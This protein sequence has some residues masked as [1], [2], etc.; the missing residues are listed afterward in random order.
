MIQPRP[1]KHLGVRR[2]RGAVASSTFMLSGKRVSSAVVRNSVSISTAGSTCAS[3]AP[4]RGARSVLSSCMSPSSGE[5]LLLH[6]AAICSMRRAFCDLV[7]NLGDDDL[8][9]AVLALSTLP[10]RAHAESA[11]AG[12]VGLRIA[13][14]S[15]RGCRRSGSRG[16]ACAQQ[17]STESLSGVGRMIPAPRRRPRRRYAAGWRSPCRPRCRPRRSPAGWG[18][19]AGS[20][21]GS[22]SSPS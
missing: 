19:R 21:T 5:L 13:S 20:T 22:C 8:P 11:A 9:G 1:Q 2:P 4:A 16:R 10:L 15:R 6:S 18:R 12:L 7:G 17:A 3:S 14:G